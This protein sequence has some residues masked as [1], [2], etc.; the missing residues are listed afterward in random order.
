MN[1]K[2]VFQEL[3]QVRI[4]SFNG[5]MCQYRD[6]AY[7][8]D[9]CISN[10]FTGS[11]CFASNHQPDQHREADLGQIRKIVAESRE[12]VIVYH[13]ECSGY[14]DYRLIYSRI[15]NSD[16]WNKQVITQYR[17]DYEDS[18]FDPDFDSDED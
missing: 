15:G 11:D 16:N 6:E 7:A 18:D 13:D 14:E 8:D 9:L 10:I 4:D 12:I 3:S 5:S 2:K 1:S 17:Y